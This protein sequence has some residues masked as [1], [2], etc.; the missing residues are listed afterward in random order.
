MKLE[1]DA[2]LV[3]SRKSVLIQS[4]VIT[5][6]FG[7]WLYRA[8]YAAAAVV[9][10]MLMFN[11]LN[12]GPISENQLGARFKKIP[13]ID[14]SKRSNVASNDPQME[15]YADTFVPKSEIILVNAI[16]A[17]PSQVVIEPHEVYV[18]MQNTNRKDLVIRTDS[19]RDL[20]V[21]PEEVYSAFR[22]QESE[23]NLLDLIAQESNFVNMTYSLAGEVSNRLKVAQKKYTENDYIE[24]NFWKVHTQIRKPSWLRLP[25]KY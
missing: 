23:V 15:S 13:Q 25:R 21:V 10:L 22:S 2:A 19:N 8:T 7:T 4:P 6:N 12:F 20:A 17:A 18:T 16:N 5:V 24:I 9:L 11:N 3:F 1:E 14:L